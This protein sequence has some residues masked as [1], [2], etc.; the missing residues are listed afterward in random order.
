[1]NPLIFFL[2]TLAIVSFVLGL[3][4]AGWVI[5]REWDRAG[6]FRGKL[7]IP[8][9]GV[10]I[11]TLLFYSLTLVHVHYS[12][13]WLPIF[14]RLVTPEGAPVWGAF[15]GAQFGLT[16]LGVYAL[17]FLVGKMWNP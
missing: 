16:F 11:H 10:A 17:K 13:V 9:M 1:M 14:G 5:G 4:F 7:D 6:Q 3:G 8:W 12:L 2:R 15:V